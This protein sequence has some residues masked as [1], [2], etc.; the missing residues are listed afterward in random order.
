MAVWVPRIDRCPIEQMVIGSSVLV[1]HWHLKDSLEVRSPSP[2]AADWF[3]L[4]MSD[5]M[6]NESTTRCDS[7]RE[8]SVSAELYVSTLAATM[9]RKVCSAVISM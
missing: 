4:A 2:Q 7:P 8:F 6:E 5:L 1:T 9:L 3:Q